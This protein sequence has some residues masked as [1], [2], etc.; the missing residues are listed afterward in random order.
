MDAMLTEPLRAQRVFWSWS[1][2]IVKAPVA[3][4]TRPL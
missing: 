3:C 1:H 4:T 2:G